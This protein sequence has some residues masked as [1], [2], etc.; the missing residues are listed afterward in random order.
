[1]MMMKMT[2]ASIGLLGIISQLLGVA[3]STAGGDLL[4]SRASA[5][6]HSAAVLADRASIRR[7]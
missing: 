4:S 7:D 5:A 1:M 2:Q 6:H 3:L